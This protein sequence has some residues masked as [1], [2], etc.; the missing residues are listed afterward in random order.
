MHLKAAFLASFLCISLTLSAQERVGE[1]RPVDSAPEPAGRSDTKDMPSRGAAHFT[2]GDGRQ[3]WID[4]VPPSPTGKKEGITTWAVH[5]NDIPGRYSSARYFRISNTVVAKILASLKEHGVD[6]SEADL[7][8]SLA[9]LPLYQLGDHQFIYTLSHQSQVSVTVAAGNV[10][11]INVQLP[12]SMT[13]QLLNVS[14]YV[15]Q[16]FPLTPELQIQQSSNSLSLSFYTHNTQ[17]GYSTTA[18]ITLPPE[19]YE[20]MIMAAASG[21]SPLMTSAD[22]SNTGA[23]HNQLGTENHQAMGGQGGSH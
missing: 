19:G 18:T 1:K 16:Q 15:A 3:G 4:P 11:G 10:I 23:A 8:L 2:M 7:L 14:P 9:T 17:L 12:A 20:S 21:T 22:D 13:Q 6:L 5:L